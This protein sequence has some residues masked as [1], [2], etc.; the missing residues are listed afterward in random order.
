[1]F[2]LSEVA[3]LSQAYKDAG[4]G[5][6]WSGGFLASIAAEGKQ[7]RGNGI[8]ILRDLMTKGAPTTWPSWLK[9]K[10]YLAAAENCLRKDEADTLRSFA[11][12]VFQGRDLTD[13]QKAYAERIM[14]GA[15]RPINSVAV[16]EELRTLANGLY[17]RKVNM[18]QYYWGNKP[19]TSNRIDR[20]IN[21]IIQ[22]NEVENE[23][24]EFLR[25]QFKA[26][27]AL[28]DSA[29]EK[30]GA[31]S[32]VNPWHL[33]GWQGRRD[34]SVQALDALVLGNR[35]FSHH[36]M[37]MVDVLVNGEVHAVNMEKLMFPKVR[38]ARKK[39]GEEV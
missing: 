37:L 16:D 33:P 22:Q 23:D 4:L 15:Q 2:N 19:A 30:T 38:K 10:D 29:P 18:S 39:K 11:G 24:V 20:V 26:V 32:Q 1:M 27:V 8:N 6:T 21:K 5:S 17:R 14:A 28:W 36:G 31:L 25:S 7:P 3:T 35:S 13:R 34:E 9:A 12:Q